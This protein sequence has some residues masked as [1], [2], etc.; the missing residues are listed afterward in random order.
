MLVLFLSVQL[1]EMRVRAGQP[2][3]GSMYSSNLGSLVVSL[4]SL[5]PE[6]CHEECKF[7]LRACCILVFALVSVA[8]WYGGDVDTSI[9]VGFGAGQAAMAW[10]LQMLL[11]TDVYRDDCSKALNSCFSC[12]CS[13]FGKCCGRNRVKDASNNV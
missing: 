10:F 7:W 2:Y 5:I 1:T 12:F 6:A 4:T 9:S 13:A 8:F 3:A 11:C